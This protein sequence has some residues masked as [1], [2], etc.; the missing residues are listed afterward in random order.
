LPSP[1]SASPAEAARFL[2]RNV[3]PAPF[4]GHYD[5]GAFDP[6][7]EQLSQA[8]ALLGVGAVADLL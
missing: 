7:R 4:V 5:D 6:S 8:I 1:L 2:L 3:F